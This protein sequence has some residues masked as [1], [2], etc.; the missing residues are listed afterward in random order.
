MVGLTNDERCVIH[1]QRVDK[2]WGSKKIMKMFTN[3]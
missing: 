2:H 1:N 3:K